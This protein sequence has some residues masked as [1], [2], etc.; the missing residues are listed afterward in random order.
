MSDNSTQRSKGRVWRRRFGT[1]VTVL[2][3]SIVVLFFACRVMQI[4]SRYRIA[5]QGVTISGTITAK[6]PKNHGGQVTYAYKV[7]SETYHD[8]GGIGD[9]FDQANVGDQLFVTYDP[10]NPAVSTIA[11]PNEDF[12]QLLV[13]A[14]VFTLVTAALT[15]LASRLAWNAL[16]R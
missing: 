4:P 2:V 10:R 12:W 15:A 5:T 6:D 8:L 16:G 3:T 9:R 14:L 1:G 11:D 7:A 13:L